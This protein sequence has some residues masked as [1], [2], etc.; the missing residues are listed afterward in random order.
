MAGAPPQGPLYPNDPLFIDQWGFNNTGQTGGT[1][2]ADI[3][4]PEAWGAYTGGP[5]PIV[6]VIDTGM[7]TNHIDL[8]GNLFVNPFDPIDGIDNDGNGFIDDWQGWDFVN[9]DN[10]VNDGIDA[11]ATHVG[12]TI[13]AMTNNGVGVAGVNWDQPIIMPLKFLQF[14][15]GTL[16]GALDAFAY[17]ANFALLHQVEIIS[18]NSWGCFGDYFGCGGPLFEDALFNLTPIVQLHLVAAGNESW[19]NDNHPGLASYPA[20]LSIPNIVSVA[21]TD[22]N[23]NL[24]GFSSFGATTVDLAAPGQSILS[25]VPFDSY[26]HFSGTSMATPHV[27]GAAAL[28][29]SANP[30][31]APAGGAEDRI[32]G[33]LLPQCGVTNVKDLMMLTVDQKPALAGKMIIGGRL[34][35]NNALNCVAAPAVTAEADPT[36]GPSPLL[37]TFSATATDSDG[38]IVDEWWNFGDG[39]PEEH[40]F[41]TQHTYAVDGLYIAVFTAQ[42]NDGNTSSAEVPIDVV[43]FGT[44]TVILVDDDKGDPNTTQYIED[45]LI[46]AGHPYIVVVPPIPFAPGIPNPA[47]WNLGYNW[48][49][50]PTL[51]SESKTWIG[52][53]L[54]LGGR[55]A[56]L[57][58]DYIYVEGLDAFLQQYFWVG[59]VFQDV[60]T[61]QVTGI[62]ENPISCGMQIPL[63]YPPEFVDF[64][65]QV[66]PLPGADPI[67]TAAD[68]APRA[69]MYEGIEAPYKSAFFGFPLEAVPLGNP[70]PNNGPELVWRIVNWLLDGPSPCVAPADP[71]ILITPQSIEVTVEQGQT[72]TQLMLIANPGGANL[73]FDIEEFP[74]IQGGVE[75]AAR[76]GGHAKVE[77][78]ST[79]PA[80]EQEAPAVFSEAGAAPA[81][82]EVVII[83][84]DGG[85][86]PDAG[87]S[88]T[89]GAPGPLNTPDQVVV[90]PNVVADPPVSVLVVDTL[91][92]G[93]G[94]SPIKG[95]LDPFPD[96][97][98]VDFID[99]TLGTPTLVQLQAYDV[100]VV[101]SNY[102]W[103]DRISMGDVLA[104]YNDAGGNVVH[105]SASF[106]T[107]DGWGL[108]GAWV[109]PDHGAILTSPSYSFD[110]WTLGNFNPGHPIMDGVTS[111]TNSIVF[112]TDFALDALFAAEWNS[113]EPL[114]GDMAP[115]VGGCVVG[116]NAFP[117]D[118]FWVGDMPLLIHNAV[119]DAAQICGEG[120]PPPPPP[121]AGSV[122]LVKNVQPWALN[123]DPNETIL[124]TFG[125]PYVVASSFDLP[126]LDLSSFAVVIIAGDQDQ[127]FY[128]NM[129]LNVPQLEDYVFNGGCLDVH[130]ADQGW[131]GGLWSSLLP[132]GVLHNSPV[133][134]QFNTIVDPLS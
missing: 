112:F 79:S 5:S 123:P 117:L 74:G 47:I 18:N 102:F 114:A 28:L 48:W 38:T 103:A 67:F 36:F 8:V 93:A 87:P 9:N 115:P 50:F 54:D 118:G 14:G 133:Y 120:A 2:D 106:D 77:G 104:A 70:E 132:G 26:D 71:D 25:T 11:H 80:P 56:L 43:T 29:L 22:H 92:G 75:Q 24:A 90:T 127:G 107:D 53:N 37:V 7:Q 110:T 105:M 51:T 91:T 57:A 27:A 116:L 35:L 83:I 46:A 125:V 52:S 65:D 84:P 31:L 41:D 113:L 32:D 68:G 89:G 124:N 20:S 129:A 85:V 39:S 42:D 12:G 69:V 45:A 94:F 72:L 108:A 101:A 30:A 98:V 126:A 73:T 134:D 109:A 122:L 100:V 21:A 59:D 1:P 10:N 99:G 88:V 4:A 128:D 16:Q 40:V 60:G 33:A 62:P 81:K 78:S 17:M 121:P 130:A 131:N 44:D 95:I 97:A 111:L 3:D 55:V 96:T 13:A 82:Q 61:T 66:F 49:I 76:L 34:N 63:T 6:A 19:D 15:G 119:V 58:Q 64:S 86:N 23:D